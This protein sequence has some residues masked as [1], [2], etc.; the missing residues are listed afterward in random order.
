M[1]KLIII[2]TLFGLTACT[3]NKLGGNATIKGTVFH[4]EK[5]IAFA[6]VFIKFNAKEVPGSDTTLY[7]AKVIADAS[8]NYSI[9]VYILKS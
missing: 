5:F 1:K 6:R 2:F 9:K 7:D 3:K 8:G 4:H